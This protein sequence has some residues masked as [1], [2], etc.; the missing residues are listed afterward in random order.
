MASSRWLTG[1]YRW[2]M[3]MGGWLVSWLP[4]RMQINL[5]ADGYAVI[6]DHAQCRWLELP[7]IDNPQASEAARHFTEQ[8]RADALDQVSEAE[9]ADAREHWVVMTALEVLLGLVSEAPPALLP[10]EVA[11]LS[12][13]RLTNTPFLLIEC[14][15]GR[16][17]LTAIRIDTPDIG[18]AALELIKLGKLH[19]AMFARET[20]AAA[21][22]DSADAVKPRARHPGQARVTQAHKHPLWRH[23]WARRFCLQ[24][25]PVD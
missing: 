21:T 8:I 17:S 23:R 2:P 11:L 15:P 6:I 5:M 22:H 16:A 10:A 25:P 7:I 20:A 4:R 1:W 13:M 24:P 9:H 3:M 12:L 14:K 18:L 19:I